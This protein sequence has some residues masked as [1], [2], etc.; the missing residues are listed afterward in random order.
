MEGRKEGNID[1]LATTSTLFTVFFSS[2]NLDR[3]QGVWG[4]YHS[5]KSLKLEAKFI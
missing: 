2:K 3:P 5:T 4:K 1:M